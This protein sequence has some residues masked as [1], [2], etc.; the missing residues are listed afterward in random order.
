MHLL[1]SLAFDSEIRVEIVS[2]IQRFGNTLSSLF[3]GCFYHTLVRNHLVIPTSKK[4]PW[5]LVADVFDILPPLCNNDSN[6]SILAL[7]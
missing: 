4:S 1:R 3:A 2:N 7:A 6:Y 5:L